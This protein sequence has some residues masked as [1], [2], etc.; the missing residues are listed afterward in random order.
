[1]LMIF[2]FLKKIKKVSIP[3]L[4]KQTDTYAQFSGYKINYTTSSVLYLNGEE[5]ESPIIK[6]TFINAKEGFMC[7]GVQMTPD[8]KITLNVIF[9]RKVKVVTETLDRRMLMPISLIR[10]VNVIKMALYPK[11][12]N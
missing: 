12:L 5:S 9:Y 10:H 6:S 2:S 3:K 4:I 11:C 7:L 8:I 1:M